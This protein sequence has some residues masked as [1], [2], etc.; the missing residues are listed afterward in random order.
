MMRLEDFNYDLAKELIAQKPHSPRDQARLLKLDRKSGKIIHSRFDKLFNFLKAGDLLVINNSQVFPARLSGSK[1]DSGGKVEVFLHQEKSPGEW[2]C[3]IKG[4]VKPNLEI[5]LSKKLSAVLIRDQGDGT[6]LLK[7][8]LKADDFWQEVNQIGQVPLPPYIKPDEKKKNEARYQTVYADSSKRGSVAAPTAGLH[9]TKRLLRQL[10]SQGIIIAPLTLHVGLGTF[11]TVK[12][13]DITKHQMHREEF[14]ISSDSLKLILEA[15][16]TG[17]RIIAVGT[18][19]CRVLESLAADL[20]N[21]DFSFDRA[22]QGATDIFIYP[23]Y[24]FLLVD[25]ILTNF[26]LPKSTLLMLISAFAGSENIKKA[27]QEAISERYSFYS[28]GDAMLII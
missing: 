21:K 26:H 2:E 9:F 8:N 20:K 23:A 22:Y 13:D 25:A 12:S 5:R 14:F 1:K 17:N 27:Y 16:K 7:F 4:K 18:T 19:S 28:Y 11:A 15:K 10:E 6:W 24:N 3:L